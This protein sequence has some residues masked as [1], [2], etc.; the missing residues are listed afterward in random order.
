MSRLILFV[1]TEN[2]CR[3]PMAE[4]LM[5]RRLPVETQWM[6]TSAGLHATTGMAASALAMDVMREI[7]IDMSIHRSKPVARE[8]VSAATVIAVMTASHSE[9]LRRSFPDAREKIFLLKSFDPK[10]RGRD[11]IDPMGGTLQ[12]YRNT[13][14]EIDLAITGLIDFLKIVEQP[15]MGDAASE[16]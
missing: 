12:G 6:V 14:N 10:A 2:I 4:H 8:W 5:K 9:Q 7:K 3:S 15:G 16:T 13:R 1:C 11:V